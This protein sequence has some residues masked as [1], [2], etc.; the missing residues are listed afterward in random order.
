MHRFH[1]YLVLEGLCSKY[2]VEELHNRGRIGALLC[3]YLHLSNDQA[4][5]LIEGALRLKVLRNEDDPGGAI[6]HK[7]PH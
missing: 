5:A 3:E 6:K 7:E 1:I 2:S 4:E